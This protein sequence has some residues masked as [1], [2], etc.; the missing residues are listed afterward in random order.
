[1]IGKKLLSKEP[2]PLS[3][4]G[5]IINKRSKE[6]DLTY[7]QNLT[8]DYCKKFNK[9]NKK[10]SQALIKEL[11]ELNNVSEK[12]AV[13]LSNLLPQKSEELQL[14]FAKEHF[15]ISE[16]EIKSVLEVLNRHRK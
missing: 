4:V 6:G 5:E 2:L 10:E 7:E 8:K 15:I 14:I 13:I 3:E 1:M 11:S 12:N 16:E 9:L